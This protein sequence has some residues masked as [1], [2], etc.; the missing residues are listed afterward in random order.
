[1]KAIIFLVPFLCFV[2]FAQTIHI[3]GHDFGL[4]F[5]DNI[6]SETNRAIIANDVERLFAP[7]TNCAVYEVYALPP[8]DGIVGSL[9]HLQGP[10][11]YPKSIMPK[12]IKANMA[13]GLNIII[14]KSLSDEYLS[15]FALLQHHQKKMRQAD[16][17]AFSLITNSFD[18]I[19]KPQLN[20]MLLT[21]AKTAYS[22]NQM[23]YSIV[24]LFP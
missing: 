10:T 16:I 24:I 4:L 23:L 8:K 1:M 18:N 21:K 19:P 6:L 3:A 22:R 12:T 5:E 11:Y 2:S 15:A 14:T 9:R 17:F 20:T 13:D 7:S